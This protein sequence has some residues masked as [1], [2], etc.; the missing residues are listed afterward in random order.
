MWDLEIS[1]TN[2]PAAVNPQL[3]YHRV[4]RSYVHGLLAV[5]T[6]R[7][8]VRFEQ[9]PFG[10]RDGVGYDGDVDKVLVVVEFVQDLLATLLG[11]VQ[12]LDNQVR[13]R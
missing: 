5:T 1:H 12:V 3:S 2:R 11:Q 8:V 10:F 4:E 6:G 9:A 13:P 7:D